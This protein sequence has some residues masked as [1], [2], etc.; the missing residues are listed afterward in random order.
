MPSKVTLK[1]IKGGLSDQ[2]FVNTEK[3]SLISE[4]QNDCEPIL[5]ETQNEVAA[6]AGYKTIRLLGE[7]TMSKVWLVEEEATAQ[8]M[9][10]KLMLP[11]VTANE[12]NRDRIVNEVLISGQL[13]HK[14]IIRQQK[15]GKSGEMYFILMEFCDGGSVEELMK[16][17]G[18]KLSVALATDIILQVLEGLIYAHRAK[19]TTTLKSG[20]I[21]SSTGV[22][23]RDVKPSNILLCGSGK[24]FVAKLADFGLDKVFETTGLTGISRA[25]QKGKTLSFMPIQQ[26]INFYYAMPDVDVWSTAASY[27]Y[28]LT[29]N[30]PKDIEKGPNFFNSVFTKAVVP[31]RK[32]D[33][34]IPEKLAEVIDHALIE[35]PTI[36]VGSAYELKKMI[37]GAL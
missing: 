18:G 12:K 10:L 2:S 35:K 11:Q 28:M 17:Q 36:G 16:K 5:T 30:Y 32:R 15:Y 1:L 13:T 37:E 4:R 23:H 33:P 8:R 29:G 19:I 22:V 21:F 3:E 6:I 24:S 34:S 25:E 14:N 7:G 31:I 27:Y 9:A 26:I 20:N